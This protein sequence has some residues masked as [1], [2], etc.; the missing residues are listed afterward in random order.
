ME[1]WVGNAG[2]QLMIPCEAGA[3]SSPVLGTK[4]RRG[5]FFLF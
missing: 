1:R 4:S 2:A 3:D 5:V